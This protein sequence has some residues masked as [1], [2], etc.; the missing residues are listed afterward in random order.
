MARRGESCCAVRGELC[1]S[2]WRV[3]ALRRWV[4]VVVESERA[5][6]T[7]GCCEAMGEV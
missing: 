3:V 4:A 6:K 1:H 7:D 5:S 2:E